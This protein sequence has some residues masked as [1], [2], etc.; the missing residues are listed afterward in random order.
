MTDTLN[1]QI[2]GKD[3]IL[4]KEDCLKFINSCGRN[5]NDHNN[6]VRELA[7]YCMVNNIIPNEWMNDQIWVN[8]NNGVHEFLNSL[9]VE[10]QGYECIIKSGRN[11]NYDFDI[12]YKMNDDRSIIIKLEFKYG[13]QHV[14]GCPQFLSLSSDFDTNYS[15]YFYDNYVSQISELYSIDM[16]EKDEYLRCVKGT[17]YSKM[18]WFQ[19]IYDNEKLHKK[20]KKNIV[21]ESIHKFLQIYQ[22]NINLNK[23]QKK[24]MHTQKGKIYMCYC[25]G[26]FVKDIIEEDELTLVK[27][28]KLKAGKNRLNHT[29]I[30]NTNNNTKIHMLLRWKNRAGILYPAWQIKLVRN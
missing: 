20:E 27:V 10:H 1:L 4:N 24:F 25:D 21:D 18:E 9:V 3:R 16:P 23:L 28:D 30:L 7:I 19:N 12:K 29:V 26:N 5:N 11:C 15:E 13:C 14:T 17:N 6:K 22:K 8:L 2:N